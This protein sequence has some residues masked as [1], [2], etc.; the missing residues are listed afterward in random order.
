MQM[1][2]LP[3][4]HAAI[5]IV[6]SSGAL[7]DGVS[8]TA[9]TEKKH[10]ACHF[11]YSLF[12]NELKREYCA[13][14]EKRGGTHCTG[15]VR[16]CDPGAYNRHAD[17]ERQALNVEAFWPGRDGARRTGARACE[18]DLFGLRKE[19]MPMKLRFSCASC[20]TV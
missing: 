18:R 9:Y 2:G 10:E 3:A 6:M 8:T 15:A 13:R 16:M 5:A 12:I 1:K 19:G 17:T 7:H 11:I 4:R 14:Q 20:K